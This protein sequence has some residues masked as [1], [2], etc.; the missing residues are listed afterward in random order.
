MMNNDRKPPNR[1]VLKG[2]RLAYADSLIVP[3]AFEEGQQ[4]KYGCS[5]LFP[6]GHP[7]VE[8]IE[9]AL[10]AAATA[11]WGRKADWPKPLRGFSRDPCVKDVADYPKIGIR[12][13]GWSFVR[14][15]SLEPPGIVDAS[16]SEVA[17]VD[18]RG[19]VYS[20]RWANI[21][22]NVFA[23]ERQTGAGASLGLGNIQLLKHDTRL[24][25][26]RPKPSEEF[27]PEPLDYSDDDQDEN[28]LEPIAPTS[29]RRRTTIG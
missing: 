19:E 3:K 24:G 20:G 23:Y 18:L 7:G 22:L 16:N 6:P 10:E 8:L 14:A 15:N 21:S 11:R 17:K 25:A 12:D 13:V 1:V 9:T 26:A 5:I 27:D 2:V 28:E 29:R 4:P